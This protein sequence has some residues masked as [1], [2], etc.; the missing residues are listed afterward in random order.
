MGD[1]G[2]GFITMNPRQQLWKFAAIFPLCSSLISGLKR[3]LQ[4]C[5]EILRNEEV[6]AAAIVR[7]IAQTSGVERCSIRSDC[8][9]RWVDSAAGHYHDARRHWEDLQSDRRLHVHR[10]S[11]LARTV[12]TEAL[13][14]EAIR[15]GEGR[16][17]S[18]VRLLFQ[19]SYAFRVG[20]GAS[21]SP[22]ALGAAPRLGSLTSRAKWVSLY[23]SSHTQPFTGVKTI[24]RAGGSADLGGYLKLC[25]SRSLSEFC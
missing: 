21:A 4:S 25:S 20:S 3:R 2:S 19:L 23:T 17:G 14:V 15:G 10:C 12:A 9:E 8:L 13:N 18:R 6:E 1:R 7:I 24:I 16:R 11:R 22:A 5:F